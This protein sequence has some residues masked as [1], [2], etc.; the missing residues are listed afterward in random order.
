VANAGYAAADVPV[1]VRSGSS[2]DARFVTQRL[3][4]PARGKAIV[5]ILIQ[6]RPTEVQVN[7]GSVPE[8][9]ASVHVTSL[10]QPEAN[11]SATASPMQP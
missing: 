9:Q 1:T 10:D 8:T 7:D 2:S 5:R 3:R 11:P 4:V 6:G